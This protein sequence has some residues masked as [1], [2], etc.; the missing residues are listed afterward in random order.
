MVEIES[1]K[2]NNTTRRNSAIILTL[3]KVYFSEMRQIKSPRNGEKRRRIGDTPVIAKRTPVNQ[4]VERSLVPMALTP[5]ALHPVK[6]QV[7][8]PRLAELA[9]IM[10]RF[11][12][13]R[14]ES[15]G[16]PRRARA[17]VCGSA[18]ANVLYSTLRRPSERQRSRCAT[19]AGWFRCHSKKFMHNSG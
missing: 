9:R 19:H 6:P 15:A 18:P 16:L 5:A 12:S 4:Q 17:P 13:R 10:H 14:G 3:Y 11:L 1:E 2:K 8:H 7:L